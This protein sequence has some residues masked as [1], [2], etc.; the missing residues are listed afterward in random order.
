MLTSNNKSSINSIQIQK[1][2]DDHSNQD[3]EQ[4]QEW[5][6]ICSLKFV[7]YDK[8]TVTNFYINLYK[9]I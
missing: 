2:I 1:T 5:S 8:S 4:D 7:D 3:Q 6:G 9:F